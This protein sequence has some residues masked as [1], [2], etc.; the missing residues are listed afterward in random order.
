MN[1][2][3]SC[4]VREGNRSGSVSFVQRAAFTENQ[5]ASQFYLLSLSAFPTHI[6]SYVKSFLQKNPQKASIGKIVTQWA[7][8]ELAV[9]V[10]ESTTAV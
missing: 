9:V 6:Q 3:L 1:V 10:V 7:L 5:A 8:K 4:A 2:L